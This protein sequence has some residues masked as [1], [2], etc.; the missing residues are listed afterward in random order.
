MTPQPDAVRYDY[1]AIVTALR[2][3]ENAVNRSV[4]GMRVDIGEWLALLH[5][6]RQVLGDRVKE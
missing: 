3:L 6:A 1:D 2:D 5:Q 4:S